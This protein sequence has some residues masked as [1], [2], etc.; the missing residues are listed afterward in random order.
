MCVIRAKGAKQA[1][2]EIKGWSVYGV[3]VVTTGCA[4]AK[5]GG[6]PQVR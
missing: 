1:G 6:Y 2:R 3:S 4:G 5:E